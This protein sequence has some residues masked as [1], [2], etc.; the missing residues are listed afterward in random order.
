MEQPQGFIDNAHLDFVCKLHKALYGLKQA[1]RAWFTQLST[2]L[3]ELG[4]KASLVNLSLFIY[5][6][7]AVRVYMLFYVDDIIITRTHVPIISSFICN[8]QHEIPLKDLGSLNFFLGNQVSRTPKGL[9]ICQIRY[10]S[11]SLTRTH[12]A[13]AK[14]SKSPCSSTSKLSKYDGDLLNNPTVYRHIFGS[15]QYCTLT[16]LEIAFSINQ[17]CL[18]LHAPTSTHLSTAKHV[19]RY[20]KG[21]LDLR[22][23]SKGSLQ[24][25]AFCDL[26]WVGCIDDRRSTSRFLVFLGDCLI[27]WSVKKQAVVSRSSAEA[28]YRS[29]AH[30]YSWTLLV[31]N[32][33]SRNLDSS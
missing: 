14:P 30:H 19:L 13:N 12:M 5:A 20:L 31:V 7:G 8:I 1:P 18:H 27:S 26:N 25:N 17:L 10:I 16:R 6:Y 11:N 4:F 24:L 23:Y 2:F 29:L 15:L 9:H 33:V 28:E 3:L 21:T 22:F 32:V